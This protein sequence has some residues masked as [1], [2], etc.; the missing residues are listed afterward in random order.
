M[1]P[2][3]ATMILNSG[4]PTNNSKKNINFLKDMKKHGIMEAI[5]DISKFT[6]FFE[7]NSSP[8][9]GGTTF[10]VSQGNPYESNF[11]ESEHT[12]LVNTLPPGMGLDGIMDH[13]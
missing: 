4:S 1:S 3:K 6:E 5:N 7:H 2:P 9:R 8:T 13:N 11:K 12:H 10:E